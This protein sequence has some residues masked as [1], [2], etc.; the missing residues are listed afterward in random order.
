[1][2]FRTTTSL[3]ALALQTCNFG[4]PQAMQQTRSC[5][6]P[7]LST[8]ASP[9]SH[10]QT[11]RHTPLFLVLIRTM[12]SRPHEPWTPKRLAGSCSPSSQ[13]TA[14][15]ARQM[16]SSSRQKNKTE[17]ETLLRRSDA[18]CVVQKKCGASDCHP[19]CCAAGSRQQLFSFLGQSSTQHN[20]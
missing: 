2:R 6:P 5:P 20:L 7:I 9:T 14:F 16:S 8:P 18:A 17:T 10:V 15:T 3:Q 4:S 19:L 1:M 12:A 11:I 13:S